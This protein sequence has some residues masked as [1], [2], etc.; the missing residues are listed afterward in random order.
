[1]VPWVTPVVV[2]A[3][4]WRWMFE[5]SDTGLVNALLINF[6]LAETGTTWLGDS[7]LVWPVLLMA[8]IWTGS[9]ITALLVLA[10]LQALPKE[11]MEAAALDGA[12]AF[13]RFRYVVLPFIK[14]TLF[15]AAMLSLVTTW[16]KFELIWALTNGG[17][18]FAT[19]ILPTYVYTL[20]F[21]RFEFGQA[22]SVAVIAMVMISILAASVAVILRERKR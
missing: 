8:S 16:F 2:V 15:A 22:A 6:N 20:A 19:S 5:G 12:G 18:G 4:I 7:V 21:E 1:M 13:R 17:P 14:P 9:P 3:L 11:T 10:G